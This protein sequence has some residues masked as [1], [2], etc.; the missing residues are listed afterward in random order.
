M[1]SSVLFLFMI[2]LAMLDN[3]LLSRVSAEILLDGIIA[4]A[5]SA[6]SIA[7]FAYSRAGTSEGK[8]GN[9]A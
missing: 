4:F 7:F 2:V 1:R 9:G 3:L 8:P 5:L 6:F